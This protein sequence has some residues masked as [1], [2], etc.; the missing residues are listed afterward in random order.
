[1]VKMRQIMFV[2]VV[3]NCEIMLYMYTLVIYYWVDLH[4]AVSKFWKIY[5]PTTY[6]NIRLNKSMYFIIM[7]IV[8]VVRFAFIVDKNG[9][10]IQKDELERL[11]KNPRAKF[12]NKQV[13]KCFQKQ[14]PSDGVLSQ[15]DIA[16][17]KESYTFHHYHKDAHIS[18]FIEH[19]KNTRG[20]TQTIEQIVDE[21]M[22]LEI[23]FHNEKEIKAIECLMKNMKN[24][25]LKNWLICY[26]DRGFFYNLQKMFCSCFSPNLIDS[27]RLIFSI[28]LG[29]VTIILFYFD[30][31]KDVVF[32][33]IL[34]HI[35]TEILVNKYTNFSDNLL[36]AYAPRM[37][38]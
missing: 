14:L 28:V 4:I 5:Y 30:L 29:I 16:L 20:N 35:W 8:L 17:I 12:F 23:K 1:M 33:S 19:L 32:F 22:K 34:D 38:Q 18:I 26:L 25:I 31:Y 15:A 3:Q 9:K 27:I 7:N 21:I 37:Q 10:N 13:I 2:L 36:I 24:P 11:N 6:Q